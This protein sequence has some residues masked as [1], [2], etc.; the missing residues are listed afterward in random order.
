MISHNILEDRQ[1]LNNPQEFYMRFFTNIVKK[2]IS[3]RKKSSKTKKEINAKKLSEV[4]KNRIR[5]NK[6]LLD[7]NDKGKTKHIGSRPH[8]TSDVIKQSI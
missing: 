2:K 3:T 8:S 6:H 7:I 1:T 5:S 4:N